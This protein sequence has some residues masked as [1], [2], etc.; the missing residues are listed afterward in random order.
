MLSLSEQ[1]LLLLTIARQARP[2]ETWDQAAER[3]RRPSSA[4]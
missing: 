3:L 2:G 4:R 1:R